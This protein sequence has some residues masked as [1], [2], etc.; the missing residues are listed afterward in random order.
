MLGSGAT[1]HDQDITDLPLNVLL[2]RPLLS[3]TREYERHD[4]TPLPLPMLLLALRIVDH[5]GVD[6]R[7]APALAR[8]S[9]RA[10]HIF[11]KTPWFEQRAGRVRLS[12]TGRA[13]RVAGFEALAAAEPAWTARVGKARVAALRAALVGLVDQFELELPHYWITYAGVDPRVTGGNFRPAKPGPP[14]IPARGQD[15][16]PVLREPGSSST[17]LSLTA[18]LS[19]ALVGFAVEYEAHLGALS[20][21]VLTLAPL[22]PEGTPLEEAPWLAGL[23]G[24]GKSRLERHGI[25]KVTEEGKRGQVARLTRIGTYLRDEYAPA[26]ARAEALWRDLYGETG[27]TH[28]RSALEAVTAKLEDGLADHP[29]LVWSLKEGVREATGRPRS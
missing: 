9:R 24:S 17:D 2:S 25:V 27:V 21:A 28:L 3:L 6:P 19:Q 18:L 10:M 8:A 7:E 15:W 12:A 16:A 26:T 23:T 11:L 22:D 14:R 13:A 20:D 5:D 4:E 1:G 29:F